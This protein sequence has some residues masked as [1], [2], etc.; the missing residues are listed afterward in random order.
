MLPFFTALVSTKGA[1]ILV[2]NA[3]PSATETALPGKHQP[4]S[5]ISYLTQNPPNLPRARQVALISDNDARRPLRTRLLE[6]LVV[7]RLD[8]LE[9]SAV[10]YRVDKNIAVDA[11]G[12]LK[13]EERGGIL[14]L[15]GR[16]EAEETVSN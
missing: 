3:L 4:S 14:R 9:R 10:R 2:A 1:L 6:H 7:D 5:A 12:V 8:E 15:E 11:D 16:G 13:R